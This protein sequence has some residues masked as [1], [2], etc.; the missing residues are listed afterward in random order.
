MYYRLSSAFKSFACI[1]LLLAVSGCASSG[2]DSIEKESSSTIDSKIIDGKTTKAEVK[3]LFGDPEDVDYRDKT[4]EIWKYV[5]SKSHY[6]PLAMRAFQS[7]SKGKKKTLTVMFE[8]NVVLKHN[9][10][11]SDFEQSSSNW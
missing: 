6:D 4:T 3:T 11:A 10:S 5:F 1:G 9:F 8:G 7:V 2:N